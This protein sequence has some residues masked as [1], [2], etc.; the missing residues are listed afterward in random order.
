MPDITRSRERNTGTRTNISLKVGDWKISGA[1]R[2]LHSVIPHITAF[3]RVLN[4]NPTPHIEETSLGA[5]LNSAAHFI[6]YLVEQQAQDGILVTVFRCLESDFLQ[7]TD[8][9]SLALQLDSAIRPSFLKAFCR[10][11]PNLSH[12]TTSA[13]FKSGQD[14][15]TSVYAIFGGQGGA[16]YTSLQELRTLYSIYGPF[17]ESLL[18]TAT[19]ILSG[20]AHSSGAVD[21]EYDYDGFELK[22]WLKEPETAP[23]QGHI[24]AAP[25]S[26]PL[27]GLLS[28][29]HFCITCKILNKC[30][31]DMQEA[32]AGVSGHSQG[33]LVAATIAQSTTWESFY[34]AVGTCLRLLFWI[35]LESHY[36]I[37]AVLTADDFQSQPSHMLSVRGLDQ[38]LLESFIDEVNSCFE[39]QHHIHLALVNSSSNL[40][41]AGPPDKLMGLYRL[42]GREAAPKDLDQSR[43]PYQKRR[44]VFEVS[45]LPISAPFHSLHLKEASLRVLQHM[46]GEEILRTN[47]CI[48]VFGTVN[49]LDLRSSSMSNLVEPLVRMVMTEPV[50]WA[51][52]CL[53][54]KYDYLLDFGPGRSSNFLKSFT[55]GSGVRTINAFDMLGVSDVGGKNEI[56]APT[57]PPKSPHWEENNGPS[58]IKGLDGGMELSTK[59]TR[60][61][62]VPPVMVA[63]MTP[64]SVPWD[65]VAAVINA[66]YHVELAAGGYVDARSFEEAIRSLAASIPTH[67]GITCNLIYVNPKSIAWQIPLIKRLIANGIKIEGLTIGAGVPSLNIATNY[68]NTIGIK[69]ISFKPS[70]VSSIRQVLDIAGANPKFPVC[71]Q[72]TGGRAGGHHSYEDFHSPIL[73]TYNE[74]RRHPNVVLIAGS[75]FGDASEVAEL[76]TGSWARNFGYSA[77]PI[78]GVLLGSRMMISREAHTSPKVK[79][80]IV[81]TPGCDNSEWHKSYDGA[82]GGV[83]T[84][85]SEMGQ[86]IHKIANR[87]VLLWKDLD[88]R[89][90]SIKNPEKRLKAL[91]SSRQEI[92]RRINSDYAKPWFAIDSSGES[93]EIEDLTYSE[94]LRR[95]VNLMYVRS[96]KR[97][98]DESY[99]KKV[100]AFANRIRERF[101]PSCH[102]NLSADWDPAL[103]LDA[104]LICYPATLTEQLY[105]EDVSYFMAL[106]RKRGEKPVNF[107]PR[108][109][110]NFETWFKKDSLWQME[111]LDAV[112]GRDP[113]RVCIIH[114]PVAISHSTKA[115]EP[116]AS[117]LGRFTRELLNILQPV[118]LKKTVAEITTSLVHSPSALRNTTIEMNATRTEYHFDEH[119]LLPEYEDFINNLLSSH[120]GWAQACLSDEH[121][122]F[123]DQPVKNPISA[124]FQPCHGDTVAVTYDEDKQPKNV[125]LNSK[126]LDGSAYTSIS[127]KLVD[128]LRVL[129]TLQIDKECNSTNSSIVF[130]FAFN[131]Q[132]QKHRLHE[133]TTSRDEMIKEFYSDIWEHERTFP[134]GIELGTE[135]YEKSIT[136]SCQTVESFMS[137]ITKS[138]L[139]PAGRETLSSRAIPLDICISICWT[140]LTKPL[141]ASGITGDL[142]R[143]LH[144]SNSFQYCDGASP[145]SIGDNLQTFFR[146]T[147]II[148]KPAGKSITVVSTITRDKKPVVYVTSVFLIRG[149]FKSDE[150]STQLIDRYDISLPVTSLKLQA[151]LRSRSW[152]KF[153][154]SD[155]PLMGTTLRIKLRTEHKSRSVGHDLKVGGQVFQATGSQLSPAIGTIDFSHPS[156]LGNPISEFFERHGGTRDS[157]KALQHPGWKNQV[158]WNVKI[159]VSLR[160]Y[161]RASKDT[162]PIHT[163]TS[164]ARYAGLRGTVAHG[165]YTSASVRR[166]I[167]TVVANGDCSRFRAWA[168]SF[169]G[170]VE[171]GDVL[172]IE[173]Q[174]VAMSQGKMV[175]AVRA[176]NSETSEKVLDATAE[177]EQGSTAYLFC[178]QGSQEKEMG[179]PL[180][181]SNSAAKMIWDRG[182]KYFVDTYGFSLLDIVFRDPKTITIYFGGKRGRTIRSNYLQMTRKAICDGKEKMQPIIP[183]L[184]PTSKSYTFKEER[185]LLFSTQFA[186]PA[187]TLMEIAEF[188][189]LKSHQVVQ[190]DFKFAGHSLGEYAAL[191][192]CTSFMTLENMLHLVFYRGLIMQNAM[193]RDGDGM[194]GFSMVALNPSKISRD[195]KQDFVRE[196]IREIAEQSGLLL[197]IVN[198]NLEGQQYVCAG[199]LQALAILITTSDALSSLKSCQ[200]T[201]SALKH[202]VAHHLTQSQD[203][204][205]PITLSRGVA[206]I[207]LNG[208]DIPFHSTHLRAGIDTYRDYLKEKINESDI[209]PEE[210]VGKWIPNLVG[211][212]FGTGRDFVERVVEVSG[213]QVLSEMLK[214]SDG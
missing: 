125:E 13:L 135:Y 18:D 48:P 83:V 126:A 151:L 167:E 149:T 69:H 115:D 140:A 38:N 70:S 66:G 183:G 143:L 172:N 150:I 178:G 153:T 89:I 56:F 35:G 189:A 205:R 165:M 2:E 210:M 85:S 136:L 88:D 97:W 53:P 93:V 72:W 26:F 113:Q 28:L 120:Q 117:I 103:N 123:E 110:E 32:L 173:M 76:L 86:P 44:P 4:H 174:H 91:Q 50:D 156:C 58:L 162:N 104:F 61:L 10:C 207:P 63:G 109:D 108:L 170:I 73:E 52:A 36:A 127:L 192:A 80:L 196:I 186:Q 203:I 60:L 171:Q 29:A 145:L 202:L 102:F 130:E 1:L 87:A 161:S 21:F 15:T 22:R 180:Y 148:V 169:D 191:A 99:R 199:N 157:A 112:V 40:V 78:D 57:L 20:L 9:H 188:E 168:C 121:V 175:I 106:C 211:V 209:V 213:S 107:I 155:E 185:G 154:D 146:L 184:T 119:G 64:T 37:P 67:R 82:V 30:P 200:Y 197:E 75:G 152:L 98:I 46:E 92:I 158:S 166:V 95:L 33:I 193:T 42:L 25:L 208:I 8:A 11:S 198:F 116:V 160:S 100:V 163:C 45:F 62:G 159:P 47:L 96:Q 133:V 65:F 142:L 43:I 147:A 111:D 39:G 14:G 204:P 122:R 49:G 77:M 105:H 3:A 5:A 144:R 124:A 31:S 118:L 187:L 129:V 179:L 27:L 132:D 51:A 71:I 128:K 194:T 81:Q 74:V 214:G 79:E 139:S 176:Y 34:E 131:H 6:S 141:V 212:P 16:N 134:S 12:P 68:I 182:D 137:T 23:D 195:M 181:N 55:E 206:T 90:F 190:Q 59:M 114:G 201:T 94:C 19:S 41:V 177:I 138:D 164:F 17:L 7:E 24:A 101:Q 54:H 84:V